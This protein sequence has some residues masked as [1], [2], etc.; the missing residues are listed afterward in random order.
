MWFTGGGSTVDS[1]ATGSEQREP[2]AVQSGA[3]LVLESH[4][5][6]R[7]KCKGERGACRQPLELGT[8]I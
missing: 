4:T 3:G 8:Q 7:Y 2:Q 6:V 1:Q 5:E